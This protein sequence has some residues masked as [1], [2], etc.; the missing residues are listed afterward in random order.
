MTDYDDQIAAVLE[1]LRPTN[2]PFADW[3]RVIAD[4]R[5]G[6]P[7]RRADRSTA[8]RRLRRPTVVALLACLVLAIPLVAVGTNGWWFQRPQPQPLNMEPKPIDGMLGIIATGHGQGTKWTAVGY[9]SKQVGFKRVN[10]KPKPIGG[11]MVCMTT[12]TGNLSNNPNGQACGGLYGMEGVVGRAGGWTTFINSSSPSV[13]VGSTA[14]KVAR[15]VAV[16]N[17]YPYPNGKVRTINVPLISLKQ[18]GG[19]IH[20]YAFTYPHAVGVSALVLYDAA[21]HVLKRLRWG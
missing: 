15:L 5:P 13:V 2:A 17:P 21:G 4:A 6:G 9:I 8:P 20:F 3:E 10:G 1:R 7:P 12:I 18:V 19:G 11:T 16:L 14:A